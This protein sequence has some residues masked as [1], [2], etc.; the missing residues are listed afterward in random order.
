MMLVGLIDGTQWIRGLS[1]PG[2][3]HG[4]SETSVPV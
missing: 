1:I 2:R 3:A 4:S